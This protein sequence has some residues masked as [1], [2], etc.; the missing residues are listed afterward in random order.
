MKYS[1]FLIVTMAVLLVGV[2]AFA[3][4]A[5]PEPDPPWVFTSDPSEGSIAVIDLVTGEA[6]EFFY[7]ANA[8]Y[9]DLVIG[10]DG[11][12][13]GCDPSN[14]EIVRFVSGDGVVYREYI[15]T[16]DGGGNGE[17]WGSGE[18]LSPQCGCVRPARET[19]SSP[20]SRAVAC[21]CARIWRSG[22]FD[23]GQQDDPICQAIIPAEDGPHATSELVP[24]PAAGF[25]FYG[26]GVTPACGRRRP[27]GAN[28]SL[29]RRNLWRRSHPPVRHGQGHRD[30]QR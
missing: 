27:R 9:E 2:S 20:T 14:Q 22:D 18:D 5:P 12:L 21:G 29:R 24:V 15:Y 17:A 3:Q 16:Y 23:G 6:E 8:Q 30:L 19:S 26:E 10:P 13:Y 11:Y 7:D 25:D 1:K 4:T 28:H